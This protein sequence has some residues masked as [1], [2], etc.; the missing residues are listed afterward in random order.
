MMATWSDSDPSSF[1]REL[2]MEVKAN[3]CLM[4]K[5]DEV[6]IDELDDYDNL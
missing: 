4:V 1:D 5:D 3:L 6:C 2:E